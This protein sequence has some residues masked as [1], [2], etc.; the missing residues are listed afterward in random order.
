MNDDT[1][2]S[3]GRIQIQPQSFDILSGL[4]EKND[5]KM[6]IINTKLPPP[7]PILKTIAESNNSPVPTTDD[8]ND[9]YEQPPI[10]SINDIFGIINPDINAIVVSQT[11]TTDSTGISTEVKELQTFVYNVNG[12]SNDILMNR[13]QL[14][15]VKGV[16]QS[17]ILSNIGG[18]TSSSNIQCGGGGP[19]NDQVKTLIRDMKQIHGVYDDENTF[20]PTTDNPF[21]N[22]IKHLVDGID[23]R[24]SNGSAS[25]ASIIPPIGK[26]GTVNFP[27]VRRFVSDYINSQGITNIQFLTQSAVMGTSTNTVS[28]WIS[29]KAGTYISTTTEFM[30]SQGAA[31]GRANITDYTGIPLPLKF[32]DDTLSSNYSN[33]NII[34]M[35]NSIIMYE[36]LEF[37]NGNVS[38][39]TVNPGVPGE[40]ETG[41]INNIA[42]ILSWLFVKTNS[43]TNPSAKMRTEIGKIGVDIANIF[44]LADEPEFYDAVQEIQ[45]DCEDTETV[46]DSGLF[47]NYLGFGGMESRFGSISSQVKK[48]DD[49]AVKNIIDDQGQE[50]KLLIPFEWIPV[51]RN[52]EAEISGYIDYNI[53]TPQLIHTNSIDDTKNGGIDSKERI[54]SATA[55]C[56]ST[57]GVLKT[58]IEL[59]KGALFPVSDGQLH[60]EFS[61]KNTKLSPDTFTIVCNTF[62]SNT[63]E[64]SANIIKK[65]TSVTSSP[66]SIPNHVKLFGGYTA[67][68]KH[69]MTTVFDGWR[70]GVDTLDVNKRSQRLDET[71]SH[72]GEIDSTDYSI[73]TIASVKPAEPTYNYY[74]GNAFHDSYKRNTDIVPGQSSAT[75]NTTGDGNKPKLLFFPYN[76]TTSA[77]EPSPR[78]QE[79]NV[80]VYSVASLLSHYIYNASVTFD[81]FIFNTEN[82]NIVHMG[83]PTP[84]EE[85]ILA[86]LDNS[87]IQHW[88][89]LSAFQPA[90]SPKLLRHGGG[91]STKNFNPKRLHYQ[92]G[93]WYHLDNYKKNM[94][95]EELRR[96]NT[97]M[98]IVNR[99]SVGW[100][101][102]LQSNKAII[103]VR[104]Q[105]HKRLHD[106]RWNVLPDIV[107]CMN[108]R[109]WEVL[110]PDLAQG[111]AAKL[112]TAKDF[113]AQR[114]YHNDVKH[115]GK[116]VLDID[117]I[118]TGH[119]L[120]GNISLNVAQMSLTDMTT[121]G[122]R[123]WS[124][125]GISTKH[126]LDKQTIPAYTD[127]VLRDNRAKHALLDKTITAPRDTATATDSTSTSKY[128]EVTA[129]YSSYIYPIVWN[130]FMS[131]MVRWKNWKYS[132]S[133]RKTIQENE[134][135]EYDAFL[136]SVPLGDLFHVYNPTQPGWENATTII[137]WWGFD[138][139]STRLDVFLSKHLDSIKKPAYRENRLVFHQI[140]NMEHCNVKPT[141]TYGKIIWNG[142]RATNAH[143]MTQFFGRDNFAMLERY[144]PMVRSDYDMQYDINLCGD[145]K[146]IFAPVYLVGTPIYSNRLDTD[147]ESLHGAIGTTSW[148]IQQKELI[149]K[150][151]FERNSIVKIVGIVPIVN[152]LVE[153][154][155]PFVKPEDTSTINGYTAQFMDALSSGG[156]TRKQTTTQKKKKLKRRKTQRRIK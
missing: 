12:Y 91:E 152:K 59:V 34:I 47:G 41:Q 148:P 57:F 10:T 97:T 130:P 111:D 52:D 20:Y 64:L 85:T 70:T 79:R 69:D 103:H 2:Y 84:T 114:K 144:G 149:S 5:D 133:R 11:K 138:D 139:A 94:N 122:A 101:D 95:P 151:V 115:F 43:G 42:N 92:M 15:S 76:K 4:G 104:P 24:N 82:G 39:E 54:L 19:V 17:N 28:G 32:K 127:T 45:L 121:A 123:N 129:S 68:I 30:A 145:Y 89:F 113:A 16:V 126:V 86:D 6:N 99:G 13:L 135:A 55:G 118:V 153:N 102:W 117:T 105:V 53:I 87:N 9:T 14:L 38:V 119:S 93:V 26:N 25:T 37:F 134:S 141:D 56:G 120:G 154:T 44:K 143:S 1:L 125:G 88:R 109:I 62:E 98:I 35:L 51:V 140:Q 106:I 75:G 78:T 147:L 100:E 142:P 116:I 21:T 22:F 67:P 156:F 36:I 108:R 112:L 131:P 29:G 31:L 60:Q 33:S 65:M 73:S 124:H 110:G 23:S 63:D 137:N 74:K 132:R 3:G 8:H 90:D 7:P 71:N 40:D 72:V 107:K 150:W 81:D 155:K 96:V 146:Q 83:T 48:L 50:R 58:L 46:T 49:S 27:S 128:M 61:F 77:E 18:D 136:A 80:S 66:Q